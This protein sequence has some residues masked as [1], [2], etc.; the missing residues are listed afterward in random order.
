MFRG[1]D[2]HALGSRRVILLDTSDY[3]AILNMFLSDVSSD[4]GR[5]DR[6]SGERK[7]RLLFLAKRA[8]KLLGQLYSFSPS[9]AGLLERT[10][11]S[12]FT[13]THHLSRYIC[14][15]LP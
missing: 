15:V 10:T 14:S 12:S 8:E 4:E 6:E 3:L 2:T 11:Y 13:D 7:R 9:C 5:E 1:D